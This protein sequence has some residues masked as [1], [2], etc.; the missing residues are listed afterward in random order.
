MAKASGNE[1][2]I[3]ILMMAL[4][5][6]DNENSFQQNNGLGI[7]MIFDI[8]DPAARADILSNLRR[9]FDRFERLK[10]FKLLENT[11]RWLDSEQAGEKILAFKYI[12]LETDEVRDFDKKYYTSG[13]GAGGDSSSNR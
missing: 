7:A 5:S 8:D 10:R 6:D 12:S 11:I 2:D 3:N 9:V 1:Q 13:Q 4:A